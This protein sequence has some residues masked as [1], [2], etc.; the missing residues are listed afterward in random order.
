MTTSAHAAADL[1]EFGLSA[2]LLPHERAN[3]ATI[4]RVFPLWNAG[5]VEAIV[6]HY[7]DDIVWRNVA[8]GQVLRGKAAV[9]GFLTELFVAIPDLTIEVTMRVPRGVYV[10]EEYV[11][12]G[13][14]L[15]P[16]FGL[17]ATG[18]ALEIPAVSML[19]MDCGVLVEDHFY[20]DSGTVMRQMGFMPA[21]SAATSTVGSV[22][23]GALAAA[24]RRGSRRRTSR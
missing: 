15:G 4:E 21:T 14:H 16:M 17:P 2:G 8:M 9:R 19:R 7:A 5:D 3:L 24:R 18:R 11:I 10:A 13:T 23:L 12:R 22:V 20:F 6:A 1:D